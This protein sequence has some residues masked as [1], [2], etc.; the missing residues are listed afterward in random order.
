MYQKCIP[1]W[2][3]LLSL[4][5]SHSNTIKIKTSI[6]IPCPILP[7]FIPNLSQSYSNTV[8]VNPKSHHSIFG[9]LADENGLKLD[10]IPPEPRYITHKIKDYIPCVHF[11]VNRVRIWLICTHRWRVNLK[12]WWFLPFWL[13]IYLRMWKGTELGT[14]HIAA[15]ISHDEI[16]EMRPKCIRNF[17]NFSEMHHKCIRNAF[18][19]KRIQMNQKNSIFLQNKNIIPPETQE[20]SSINGQKFTSLKKTP[21]IGLQILENHWINVSPHWIPMELFLAAKTYL[22]SL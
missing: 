9:L 6:H 10:Q 14:N 4:D 12:K 17:P 22:I 2:T 7:I 20:I 5:L 15:F 3:K 21:K 11:K 8:R 13:M 16:S 19:L 18:P 1:N